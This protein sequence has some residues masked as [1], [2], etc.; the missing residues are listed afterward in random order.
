MAKNKAISLKRSGFG[1]TSAIINYNLHILSYIE[2]DELTQ[3]VAI[4]FDLYLSISLIS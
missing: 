2:L 4:S 3:L 1:K